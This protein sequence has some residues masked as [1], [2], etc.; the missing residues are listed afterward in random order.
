MKRTNGLTNSQHNALEP[1]SVRSECNH[2][3]VLEMLHQADSSDASGQRPPPGR[4]RGQHV[5]AA[6]SIDLPATPCVL[7][8]GHTCHGAE[9]AHL[10]C[11]AGSP[12]FHGSNA[13]WRKEGREGRLQRIPPERGGSLPPWEESCL[14]NMGPFHLTPHLPAGVVSCSLAPGSPDPGARPPRA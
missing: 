11:K 8:C 14:E 13:V 4:T 12:P 1:S 10:S 9:Q 2:L 5:T 3:R 6:Q 7:I